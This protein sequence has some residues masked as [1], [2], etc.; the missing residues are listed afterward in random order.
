MFNYSIEQRPSSDANR[1]AARQEFSRI[2]WNPK[3]HY[4]IHKW[5]PSIPILS[6]L[7]PVHAPHSTS[8]RSILILSS[9]LC[10][11]LP[12]GLVPSD[13]PTQTLY[14][15]LL[16][17]IHATC[18]IHLILL[19]LITRTILG[20][21]YRSLSSSLCSFLHSPVTT[22]LLGPNILLGTLF[23]NNFSLRSSL[24]V[25]DQVSYPYKTTG[26]IIVLYTL[27]FTEL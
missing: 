20:E 25:S 10:L 8:W 12:S 18:P 15:P 26:K 27:N 21:R 19:Y 24:N 16:S 13:F 22:S 11:V 17:S 2:L 1:F 5:P 4:G 3:V 14:A 9:H 7:D 6:Q 23:S